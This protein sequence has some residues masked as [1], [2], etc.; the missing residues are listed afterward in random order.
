M[1]NLAG[2]PI[3]LLAVGILAI[4]LFIFGLTGGRRFSLSFL[5]ALYFAEGVVAVLPSL[6]AFFLRFSVR[7]PQASSAVIF[8]SAVAL[9]T[10]FLSGS[11]ATEAFRLSG[12]GIRAMGSIF[13]VTVVSAGLFAV[14]FFPLLPRGTVAPS[15]L[16]SDWVLGGPYPFLWVLASFVLIALFRSRE[17]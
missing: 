10:W 17:P 14:F 6:R 3:D 13:F 2:L 4:A 8:L 16:L 7:F 5:I 11:A 1:V 15:S 9:A 12:R